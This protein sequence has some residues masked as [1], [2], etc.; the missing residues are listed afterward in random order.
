MTRTRLKP[1]SLTIT[2]SLVLAL[3]TLPAFAADVDLGSGATTGAL[4]LQ[5]IGPITFGSNG[6]L[7][8]ADSTRAAV[9]AIDTGDAKRTDAADVS[10]DDINAKVAGLLG[11]TADDIVINDVA[12]NPLSNNLYLSITRGQGESAD[13]A[14]VTA[15]ASGK[16]AL[17]DLDSI[18]YA[19]ADLHDAPTE[20]QQDRRGRALRREALT[21]LEFH[22]GTLLV[23]GLSNEEF[24]SKLRKF[25]FPFKG[26]AGGTNVEIFHG[27]H[28]RWETNAPVRTMTVYDIDGEPNVLAAY[29]CTP[30]VKFP[31]SDLANGKKVNGHTVAELGNRN[32]PLDMFVY[33]QGS[34]D[35]VLMANSSRGVMKI[36]LNRIDEV[37]QITDRVADKAGLPYET[38]AELVGVDQLAR[39]GEDRAVVLSRT[40]NGSSLRTIALP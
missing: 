25:S 36:D 11:T 12:V 27:A 2:L 10:I 13:F 38:I 7:F 24:S 6:V 8:V 30:L 3:L 34:T 18:R 21:D 26:V 39:Y 17:L 14:I 20:D 37:D 33:K 15:S 28:G 31:M 22:Q 1:A 16:L 35:Y 19:K 9:Y 4:D 40:D 5:S 23:T 32:R 29:T